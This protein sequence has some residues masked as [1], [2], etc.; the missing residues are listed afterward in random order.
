MSFHPNDIRRRG[1]AANVLVAGMLSFLM[2]GFFRSQ[3]VNHQRYTLQAETNRLREIPLP[4]PRGVI[5][6]RNRKVIADNVIGYS[7][8]VLA[9]KEDSLRAVL[10]RLSGTITMTPGQIEQAMRRFRRAP[11]RPTVVISDATFDVVSVLEEHRTQFPGLIIQSA[12]RR[13]YPDGDIVAAFVGYTGEISE[14]ELKKVP[15]SAL[16]KAGQQIGKQ[17]L[18]KQYESRLRGKEGSQFVEIDARGRIVRQTGARPDL[19]PVA[20][21]DLY[22]NI[23][24]DLQRLGASLFGDSLQGGLV[25]MD[26][27]T[28][29]VLA[30]VSAPSYDVNRFTGGIAPSYYDSLRTDPRRPLYNKALQGQYPPGSTFKLATAVMGLENK[31]VR[32]DS[33]MPQACAGGL[34][35]GS[36]YFRCEGK[37]GSLD[38]SRAIT[39]SCN[40]YFY[41]LGIKIGLTKLLAGG[42]DLGFREKAGIDLPEERRPLWPETTEYFN[43]AYGKGGWTQSVA[44]NLAIGQGENAQTILA[45]TRF[46]SALSTN[47]L[48]ATPRVL[49]GPPERKQIFNIPKDQ[50]DTLRLALG[51]VVEQGTA[52]R[53]KIEGVVMG[54]KTGTAQ[55]GKFHEN[56]KELNFAWFVGF[57]PVDDP[58]IVVA[59]MTE[60][61]LFHGSVAGTMAAKIVEKHLKVKPVL[62]VATDR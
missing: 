21:P 52:R 20:A 5:Y 6:D 37:H 41:Q 15:D 31:L 4:A 12:P 34:Q 59:V 46:Y 18:E 45:M 47:G 17:G 32:M 26:P 38:L 44:L 30:I 33:R 36:R 22:T 42:V 29:E 25:A 56:G 53:S 13:F 50:M 27:R 58:K 9:P 2:V 51:N 7:V 28:G 48:A 61:V 8:S 54:G 19:T 23:D 60:Y 1:I 57:A 62:D 39:V 14:N 49:K 11:G 40:T 3:I 43:K 16:Y 10:Q 24:M 35:Y 55:S